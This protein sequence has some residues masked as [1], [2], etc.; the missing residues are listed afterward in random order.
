MVG[1]HRGGAL[2]LT[3]ALWPLR[4]SPRRRPAAE[5]LLRARLNS[6]IL[7]SEPGMRRDDNTDAVLMHV[8]EGLVG[9]RR[10]TARS[11][12]LLAELPEGLA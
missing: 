1:G 8:V 4:C 5:T 11:G 9:L 7:S 10:R 3:A 2:A 6:D 12:P